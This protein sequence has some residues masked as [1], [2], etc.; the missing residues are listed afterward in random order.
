LQK[1]NRNNFCWKFVD[2]L[3]FFRRRRLRLHVDA[4]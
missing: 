4:S 2:F 3:H 1:V